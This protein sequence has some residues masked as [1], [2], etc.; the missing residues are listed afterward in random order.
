MIAVTLLAASTTGT[1]ATDAPTAAGQ[2]AV[3]GW[4]VGLPVIL[5]GS[6]PPVGVDRRTL[7]R[8]RVYV[9]A[10]V[11]ATAGAAPMKTVRHPVSGEMVA[12][13]P[14]QDTI[15][16]LNSATAPK[17]AIGYFVLRGPK[18]ADDDVRVQAQP[19]RS[20]PS[21]PLIAEIRIGSEWVKVNNHVVI[22][23]GL[24]SGLLALEYF[25]IGGMMWG[26]F[27]ESAA[28]SLRDGACTVGS[29]SATPPIDWEH[30]IDH[31]P[32]QSD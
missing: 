18:A 27:F 16:A 30:D 4:Y 9:H 29:P 24:K 23:Y 12:L 25:D 14:H 28:E 20:W 1:A 31:V 8:F 22:E 3:P 26:Q 19:E 7:P 11:S 2:H 5:R 13:P 32:G 15:E 21:S 17:L 6:L 10:P